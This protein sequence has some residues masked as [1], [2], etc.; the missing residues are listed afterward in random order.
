MLAIVC[1]LFCV[2]TQVPFQKLD[3]SV[4]Y[5]QARPALALVKTTDASGQTRLGSG[6]VLSADGLIATNYHVIEGALAGQVK[7]SNGDEYDEVSIVDSDAH[8]DIALLKVR[9]ANLAY[10]D[11]ANSE[12]V[13]VGQ[14]VYALGAPDGSLSEGFVKGVRQGSEI[15][16]GFQGFRIIQF[17]LIVA[18]SSSRNSGGPLLDEDAKVV[19]FVFANIPAAQNLN[20]AIPSNYAAAMLINPPTGVGRTLVKM[21]SQ[22]AAPPSE[23]LASAKTL[24]IVVNGSPVF[25]VE[26]SKKLAKW[27]RLTLVSSP[28]EADLLLNVDQTGQLNLSTGAGNQATAQLV[29]RE[30]GR[31]LWGVTKGGSWAMSGYSEAWVAHAVADEFVKFYKATVPAT[32]R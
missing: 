12:D 20:L 11:L 7:L 27:G 28:D 4:V 13:E 24:S 18:P 6:V 2:S 23:I 21:S 8:K 29:H 17:S 22:I 3:A 19:G 26:I 1:L 10:L 9:A 14:R 15:A 5:Q 31:E 32:N 16:P 25:K 30:T